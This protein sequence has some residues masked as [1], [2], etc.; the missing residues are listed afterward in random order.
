MAVNAPRFAKR[1]R[2]GEFPAPSKTQNRRVINF[3]GK[4]FCLSFAIRLPNVAKVGY[5]TS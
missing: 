5:A 1:A 2:A 4:E 3:V